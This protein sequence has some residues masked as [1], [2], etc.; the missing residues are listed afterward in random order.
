MAGIIKLTSKSRNTLKMHFRALVAAGHLHPHGQ[1]R[2][3][4]YGISWA[5]NQPWQGLLG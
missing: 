1:G 2:G 5:A 4:W 3:S